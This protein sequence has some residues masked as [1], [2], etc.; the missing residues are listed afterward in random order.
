MGYRSESIV[1][2]E[3]L[4]RSRTSGTGM[5]VCQDSGDGCAVHL[6]VSSGRRTLLVFWDTEDQGWGCQRML[7]EEPLDGAPLDSE[8][9]ERQLGWLQEAA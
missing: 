5:T 3:R 6:E 2:M 7:D 9:L 8:E 1:E 4:L